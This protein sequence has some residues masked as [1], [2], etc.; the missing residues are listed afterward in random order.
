VSAEKIQELNDAFRT[1]MAGGRVMMT[2][3]VDA[4]P[5]DV[6][7]MVIRRVATFSEFTPDNDP[8]RRARLRQ[9]HA[10]RSEVLFQAG[11]LRL[12]VDLR[13]GGPGRSLEDD[14]RADDHACGGILRHIAP[15]LEC[16]GGSRFLT[17]YDLYILRYNIFFA[18]SGGT[19]G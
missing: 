17:T 15:P 14:P 2:A 13:L 18:K 16:G 12:D 5:S 11:L 6:K 8:Q 9:L 1:T 10:R 19:H 7:A 3:G 4:L